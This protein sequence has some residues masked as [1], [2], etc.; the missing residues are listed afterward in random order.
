MEIR[1]SHVSGIDY[2]GRLKAP[3]ILEKKRRDGSISHAV[4]NDSLYIIQTNRKNIDNQE[5]FSQKPE[6]ILKML[7]QK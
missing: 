6:V 7:N 4:L 5:C 1:S 3:Q 2:F